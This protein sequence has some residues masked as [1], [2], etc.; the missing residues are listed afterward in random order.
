MR[1]KIIKFSGYIVESMGFTTKHTIPFLVNENDGQL[2]HYHYDEAE[3]TDAE[4]DEL[5]PENCDLALCEKHFTKP[6]AEVDGRTVEVDKYYRHFKV[7]KII[8]VLAVATD[9]ECPGHK[10]VVYECPVGS[11]KVYYR[12]ID[13]FLSEVDHEK[14]PHAKQKYR[15]ELV[16]EL[17][18]QP[19][20]M[21]KTD[22]P[23][24]T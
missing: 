13:M 17:D 14:Y 19:K 15:F 1:K 6:T 24:N 11:G 5:G 4:Y 3:L 21:G 7:G 2:R 18:Y 9:T 20:F 10:S 16:D 12:P 23:D 8:H 22:G